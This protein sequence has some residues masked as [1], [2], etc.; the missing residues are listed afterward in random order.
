MFYKYEIKNNGSEDILY[1]YLTMSYEFSKEIGFKSDDMEMT[2]RTKNFIRNN[3]IEYSGK[4][5]YLVIDDIIV[6]SLDI[7]SKDDTIETLKDKL[8]YSNDYYFI[9]IKLDNEVLIEITLRE[10][11]L[12]VIANIYIPSLEKETLKA[13]CL[14]Y[15][16][17]AY[18]E[19]S[20]KK[21]IESYNDFCVYRPISYYKL[22]WINN[23][24]EVYNK[25]SLAIEETDCL[26]ASYN[27]YYIL[28]FVHFS[29]DGRTIS[30]EK[31][32]YLSSVSSLWDLTSP[33][34][35]DIKDFTYK[36]L[37][38]ILHTN[39][40]NNSKFEVIDIDENGFIN[41]I[42]IDNSIFIGEDLIK[43]LG[44]KSR[45]INIIINKEYIKFISRGFG[46]FMGLSIYGANEIAKNGCDF[47]G[48][49]KYYFP[50][51]TINKY[52]KE[53]P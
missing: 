3:G 13:L 37:S 28:P 5:V 30:S 46:Y 51:K 45:N 50:N 2:R 17:Y 14:L 48:I 31:Y 19:M 21:Y 11:L 9:T 18:K 43:L 15:R 22:T 27:Q 42:K 33:H 47:I 24:D 4:K 1:L 52:I 36:E 39:I 7:S 38:R 6:K 25:I 53:L 41:K 44:L 20:E 40:T 16:S 10:F 8:Y 26:F 49:I 12:G 32:K 29:N 35:I 34:Y 23:Y